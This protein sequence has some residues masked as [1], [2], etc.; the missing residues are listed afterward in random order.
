MSGRLT[1]SALEVPPALLAGLA[2]YIRA[3][4]RAE[5]SQTSDGDPWVAIDAHL[6]VTRREAAELARAGHVEGARKLGKRWRARRSACDAAIERVGIAP[7]PLASAGSPSTDD[8]QGADAVLA[9]LG[10]ERVAA[11][12]KARR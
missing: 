3:A 1:A 7:P 2:E 6:G 12:G 4:V 11:K 10:L 5:A 8:D 9:E